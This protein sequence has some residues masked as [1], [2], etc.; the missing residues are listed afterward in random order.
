MGKGQAISI[1]LI[2]A[3]IVFVS[4][5]VGFFFIISTFADRAE[6]QS[7]KDG[8]ENMAK[9]LQTNNSQYG[10]IKGNQI[11]VEMLQQFSETGYI[12]LQ[13]SLGF[14]NDF[15]IYL[16]D[17]AGNIIPIKMSN[18]DSKAGIGSSKVILGNSTD[19]FNCGVTI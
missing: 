7:L 15:C 19:Q 3:V 18:G 1:D 6:T 17:E 14:T 9:T 16:E 8:G 13:K 10:F 4:I 5:I 11:E 2:L 12:E